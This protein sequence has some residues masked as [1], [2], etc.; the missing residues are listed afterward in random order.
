MGLSRRVWRLGLIG[1]A[2]GMVAATTA[3]VGNPA[4]GAAPNPI[5]GLH[6][7]SAGAHPD[8][9]ETVPVNV[10]L[11]GLRPGTGAQ[12]VDA[13][14]LISQLPTGGTPLLRDPLLYYGTKLPVGEQWRY[15]YRLTWATPEFEAALWTELGSLARPAPLTSFQGIYNQQQSRSL[16]ITDNSFIDA[17]TVESWL[18]AN[19]RSLLGVDTTQ[20][21]VFYVDWFG[22]PG[23]RFHVYDVPQPDPDTGFDFGTRDKNKVV[24]FGGTPPADPTSS[25]PPARVWFDDLSAGPDY[26][27]H[28]YDLDDLNIPGWTPGAYR[29]PPVWEYGNPRPAQPHVD[30]SGDLAKV[31]RFVALDMLFTPSPLYSTALPVP[32][33]PTSVRVQTTVENL[34]WS[35]PV[36]SGAVMATELS[37][38][39]PWRTFSATT[40]VK[41]GDT[42]FARTYDCFASL[43]TSVPQDCYGHRFAGT[44][45]DDILLY[46]LDHRTQ[47]TDP[48]ADLSIAVLDSRVADNRTLGF[49]GFSDDDW[50][51]GVQTYIM[52]TLW[53]TI[54]QIGYGPTGVYTHEV[55]H[56]LGLSHPH[57]GYDP[58]LGI[59]VDAGIPD[60]GFVYLGDDVAS[61]MSYLRSSF[62][63]SQFDRDDVG[64]W[65][66]LS[67]LDEANRVLAGIQASPRATEVAAAVHTA[68]DEAAAG[69]SQFGGRQFTAAATTMAKAYADVVAAA[70]QIGVPLSPA[71]Y[72]GSTQP[73]ASHSFRQQG[74]PQPDEE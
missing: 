17:R 62:S 11:V 44:P 69:L 49:L 30:L 18:A 73:H 66:V 26:S 70:R 40:A 74:P 5:V 19:G 41:N 6:T 57:D 38:L 21:T 56:Y 25:V 22:Q 43:L 35:G 3:A 24:A 50:V 16:D 71:S 37:K 64:R 58:T 1:A 61:V 59:E 33:Q 42:D 45:A 28:G 51:K 68:D 8:I 13:G 29:L 47:L 63:F 15:D 72:E 4:A 7:L 48:G 53:P 2:V 12:Q 65:S 23:F 39:E 14:R 54:Y 67:Y 20:D 60:Y 52:G 46:Y 10:V 27:A 9:T 32:V 34:D 31:A 55:G 36:P